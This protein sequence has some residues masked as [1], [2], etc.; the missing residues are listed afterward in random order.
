[1]AISL[2]QMATLAISFVILAIII[3]IGGTVLDEVQD[4]QTDDGYAYN[5]TGQGLEGIA[6]FGDWLPTIAVILA[7]A[8][9]IGI[10]ASYFY[11]RG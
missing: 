1:M 10:V 2:G 4:T 6:T 3:G 7:S 8:L 11:F 5:A 9:V